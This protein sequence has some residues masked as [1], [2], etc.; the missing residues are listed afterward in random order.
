MRTAGAQMKSRDR[1]NGKNKMSALSATGA[2]AKDLHDDVHTRWEK[3][4]KAS[5]SRIS[6]L[7]HS[8]TNFTKTVGK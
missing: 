1:K 8:E 4:K 3:V 6:N 7:S 5:N 2:K